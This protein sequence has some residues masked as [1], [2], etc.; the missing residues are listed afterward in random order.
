MKPSTEKRLL[1]YALSSKKTISIALICLIIAVGLELTGPFIAKKI[2]DNHIVG[3]Q[4]EWVQVEEQNDKNTIAYKNRFLKRSDRLN[5]DDQVIETYTFIQSSRH[6]YLIHDQI[7][8]DSSIQVVNDESVTV[9]SNNGTETVAAEKVAVRELYRFFEPELNPI[10]WLLVLYL[11]L[12]LIAAIF[13]YMKTYLL[14]VHANKIIQRM[15]N[16]VFTK[17]EELP[18]HY[19]VK[20]PAGKILARVTNDTEA[21]KELYVKVLETFVNG[22]IYMS[23]I[24][25][26]LFLLNETLAMICLILLPI[27]LLFMKFYKKYAGKYNRV[28]RSVNSDINAS[29]NE[30]IQTMP[31][32]QA[33]R[34]TDE[35]QQEF[36][37]LN[38]RH[39]RYQKKMI[40]L[41]ALTS[42]NLVNAIRGI[43]FVGFIWY[44]GSRSFSVENVISTGLLYAFVDYL[45]RLFEPLTQMVNQLPQLEQARVSAGRVFE[46][47]DEDSEVIDNK[48]I[49]R[50]RGEVTFYN[51]SFAYEKD[52]YILKNVA[53]TVLP[54]QTVAFVGYTGSGKSSIMNLLFRFYDPQKGI[55]AIDGIDSASLT[56][57]QVRQHIGIVLQD[58]FIFTGTV[59]SNITLDDPTI[60][61]EQ[62]IAALKAVGAD[63]FIEKLPK[64]YD[65]PVGEKG[66]EFS[67]GQRQLLS[68]AR[69]LAFNPAILVLDEATANIDTE[70]EGMIQ[71]AMNILAEGRTML[72]IAHRLSTIQHADQIIVLENGQIIEKGTHDQLIEE[73]GN[74]YQ[75][76]KMQQ[77]G[78]SEQAIL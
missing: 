15:R 50:I 68:F 64:Q 41:S 26:A 24:M 12:I 39:Y 4:T 67:T 43:A 8:L 32:I 40:A 45:T 10:V 7:P 36:E 34:R 13:Q 29:I 60:K 9:T 77:G 58:P 65:E 47:L 46:L 56:R 35:R 1:R 62:A 63:R 71:Q 52:D 2:I 22:F 31:I 61:R 57:Q 3:I 16:D 53:F 11:G 14:Q 78:L 73:D 51:V 55:I 42:F 70:T 72:V 54:G 27:L 33:F 38:D 75:M 18:M 5:A 37:Q 23:G 25:I 21:I 59:L 74:Y 28:I 6:Y 69:A 17:V 30:S 48:E 66:S 20:Q 44:F 49:D 19:F 76:F